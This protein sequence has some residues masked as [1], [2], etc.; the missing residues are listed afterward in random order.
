MLDR[1]D[2][3]SKIYVL[4]EYKRNSHDLPLYL[5]FL[6]TFNIHL[7]AFFICVQ[8][9]YRNYVTNKSWMCEIPGLFISIIDA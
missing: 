8:I 9:S 6:F 1:I 2:C 3:N 7:F 4:Q 5:L